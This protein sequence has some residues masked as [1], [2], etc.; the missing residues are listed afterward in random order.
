M[1]PRDDCRLLLAFT[2]LLLEVVVPHRLDTGG[3][4]ILLVESRGRVDA[5]DG[6][7]CGRNTATQTSESQVSRRRPRTPESKSDLP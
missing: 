5:W 2:R 7:V 4:A 3:C 1:P 6:E